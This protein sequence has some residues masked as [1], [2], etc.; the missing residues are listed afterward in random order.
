MNHSEDIKTLIEKSKETLK[1][2][3]ETHFD[4]ENFINEIKENIKYQRDTEYE[5]TCRR[6]FKKEGVNELKTY[7]DKAFI[8]ALYKFL[9]A[10]HDYEGLYIDFQILNLGEEK[11]KQKCRIAIY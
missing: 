4:E 8:F 3:I 2:L 9:Q 11:S 10:N 5:Q 1:S 7:G 6:W